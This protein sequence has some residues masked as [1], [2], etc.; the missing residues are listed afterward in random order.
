MSEIVEPGQDELDAL[1]R[2]DVALMLASMRRQEAEL[3]E[4]LLMTRGAVQALTHLL[5]QHDKEQ[6]DDN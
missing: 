6:D 4:Q 2:Q 3:Q 5:A 1:P